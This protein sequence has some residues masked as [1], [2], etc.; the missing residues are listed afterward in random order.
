MNWIMD[1]GFCAQMELRAGAE[2]VLRNI[3]THL[4][5]ATNSS[6][7]ITH[8]EAERVLNRQFYKSEHIHWVSMEAALELAQAQQKPI[9]AISIDG[10]LA[11]ETC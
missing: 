8:E 9:H 6:I 3:T 4:Q 7:A 1:V 2:A 10:P 5:S 11:D